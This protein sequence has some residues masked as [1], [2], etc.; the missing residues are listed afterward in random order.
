M[1]F[2]ACSRQVVAPVVETH[3]VATSLPAEFITP[4]AV[5]V[6][7]GTTVSSLVTLAIDQGAALDCY[8]AKQDQIVKS[9]EAQQISTK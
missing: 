3:W 8:K 4:C 9:L 5:P 6:M 1:A 7:T 2:C